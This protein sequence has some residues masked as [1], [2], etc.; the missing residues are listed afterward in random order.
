MGRILVEY[1][2][3]FGKIPGKKVDFFNKKTIFEQK[4]RE[5]KQKRKKMKKMIKKSVTFFG[6]DGTY[7]RQ[8]SIG[9]RDWSVKM[10]KAGWPARN[11]LLWRTKAGLGR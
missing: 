8:V 9:K 6:F 10:R 7:I 2:N 4:S 5:I 1:K 11:R 3:K